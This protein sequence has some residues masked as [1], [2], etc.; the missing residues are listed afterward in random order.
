MRFVLG[1]FFW[2]P[3][4]VSMLIIW[5]KKN[6]SHFLLTF[7]CSKIHAALNAQLQLLQQFCKKLFAFADLRICFEIWNWYRCWILWELSVWIHTHTQPTTENLPIFQVIT[8]RSKWWK[9]LLPFV[10]LF[11]YDERV[12]HEFIRWQNSL[13]YLYIRWW[14]LSAKNATDRIIVNEKKR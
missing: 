6:A 4:I 12:Q 1:Y 3:W 7:L 8:L 10:C 13:W 5:K 9:H 14:M 11:N 2:I